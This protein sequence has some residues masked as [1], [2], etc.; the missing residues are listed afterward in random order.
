MRFVKCDAKLSRG[1]SAKPVCNYLDRL[2]VWIR[3]DDGR[4][5]FIRRRSR[6]EKH[7][8]DIIDSVPALISTALGSTMWDFR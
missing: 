7:S 8:L 3:L 5:G 1:Q 2:T 6:I 4:H